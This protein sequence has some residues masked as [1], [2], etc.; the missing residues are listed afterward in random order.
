MQEEVRRIRSTRAAPPRAGR[1]PPRPMHPPAA[2][3]F[4]VQPP[5]C[6]LFMIISLAID[7]LLNIPSHGH[8]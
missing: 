3:P 6:C 8:S 1:G 5:Y 2:P 7:K 4:I